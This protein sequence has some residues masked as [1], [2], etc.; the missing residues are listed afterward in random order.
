MFY[1]SLYNP[2]VESSPDFDNSSKPRVEHPKLS[3][4]IRLLALASLLLFPAQM[5]AQQNQKDV[6]VAEA[7]QR[8]FT[9]GEHLRSTWK[10]AALREAIVKYRL[11]LA[12]WRTAGRTSEEIKTLDALGN[13]YRT[14]GRFRESLDSFT[15]GLALSR[16]MN[17]KKA[18]AEFL[19]SIGFVHLN[20]AEGAHAL[21][22]ADEALAVNVELKSRR[23][24]A[25]A[26]YNLAGAKYYLGETSEALNLLERARKLFAEERDAQGQA[27]ALNKMA[28]VYED[29]GEMEAAERTLQQALR[30]WDDARDPQGHAFALMLLGSHRLYIGEYQESLDLA[31]RALTLFTEIGDR[32]GEAACLNAVGYA[33][34]NLGQPDGA[35]E[36]YTRAYDIFRELKSPTHE[37]WAHAN[38][39][40]V[41]H[42]KGDDVAA[43]RAYQ[44]ALPLLRAS[45]DKLWEAFSLYGMGASYAALGE[46]KRA[47]ESYRSALTLFRETGNRR[48]EANALNGLGLLQQRAGRLDAA[49]ETFAQALTLARISGDPLG[50][51]M[52]LHNSARVARDGGRLAQARS[53]SADALS[54]IESAR[55]KVASSKLRISFQAT[56]HQYYELH[57]DVLMR[58]HR[59]AP[60]GGHAAEALQ[61]SE[62]ARARA[63]LEMLNEARVDMRRGVDPTLVERER[64]ISRA[65][66]ARAERQ[67]RLLAE[68]HAA[69]AEIESLGREINEL[70]AR[71]EET[72]SEIRIKSPRHAALTSLRALTAEEIRRAVSDNDTILLEYMLGEERSYLWVVSRDRIEAFELPPRA[73]I[74]RTAREVYESLQ[75][76]R[77]A[78]VAEYW[79]RAARLSALILGPVASRLGHSRLVVVPD[80]LLQYIPFGALPNPETTQNRAIAFKTLPGAAKKKLDTE[81]DLTP[82]LLRHEVASVPSVSALVMLR[83]GTQQSAALQKSLLVFADPVFDLKDTRLARASGSTSVLRGM[84]ADD[85]RFSRLPASRLEAEAIAS[86][87]PEG[88]AHTAMGFAANRSR[89]RDTELEGYR[90]IHFATHGV[91]HDDHP[92]LS[93]LV[94]S[95]VDERG[96]P[97]DG[98]LRL[99]EIYNL[100]LDADLV[101]LSACQ[102]A[103]GKEVRGE[104]LIGLVRGFMHAGARRVVASLWKVDDFATAELM[105]E[106]YRL[107]LKEDK[108]PSVALRDAKLWMWSQK[109]RQAP[110]YWAAFVLQGEYR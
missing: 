66:N 90:F 43:I 36:H 89:V 88:A 40:D 92:E 3:Q 48:W 23:V 9:E 49:A 30:L 107:M 5:H 96:R 26:L 33:Y 109:R 105:G 83:A 91:L 8:A 60:G 102:T 38:I 85:W 93:G 103:L 81:E 64:S 58:M 95:L 25:A 65:L 50:E 94:L 86:A 73:L 100:K 1:P 55:S 62:N 32:Y 16:S 61:V 19:N 87:A 71:L 18:E 104:G 6:T 97:V 75:A 27:Q 13:V 51:S 74:E 69:R 42:L 7:A 106:F 37:G 72:Q 76:R 14:L 45:K 78:E 108:S 41:H 44:R 22:R 54:I 35:L 52:M 101:V 98:F 68:G 80:G 46:V 70:S 20:L 10:A 47:E 77:P 28:W 79:R 17:D 2:C 82:L 56:V 84:S 12:A 53:L 4:L 59:A 31:R 21:A 57:V 29:R 11:A 63:L 15:Q 34:Y 39:G 99:H 24:E 67:A 110:Y